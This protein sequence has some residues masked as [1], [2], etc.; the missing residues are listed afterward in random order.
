MKKLILAFCLVVSAHAVL[1]QNERSEESSLAGELIVM[2]HPN[3]SIQEWSASFRKVGITE[4]KRTQRLAQTMNLWRIQFDPDEVNTDVALNFASRMQSTQIAQLNHTNLVVRNTP[5][6]PLFEDQW[7]LYNDGTNGGSGT[8]DID[9]RLAWDVT[10]GGVTAMGDT[11]VV[12]VIDAGFTIDHEDLEANIFINRGEVPGN[13]I[14]DDANGYIDDVSGWNAYSN[15][16]SQS[17]SNHGTHVAGTVGA[18]GNNEIGVTGVNWNVKVLPISGSSSLESTVLA[19]Y[20]YVLDMRR[21]YNSTGGQKGAY[22]VSTNASFGVDYGDPAEYPNW[23][24]MY[25]SMG[26]AGIIS[27]GA[28]AN[29]NI[30]VDVANDVPTACGSNFLLSVTNTTSSDVKNSGAAFGETTID[31]GAPGTNIRSTTSSGYGNLTGTSMATPHVAGAVALM[32]SALCADVLDGYQGNPAGLAIYMR[33]KLLIEGVDP[34]QSLEGLTVTGGRLNLYK[35]VQS[36]VDSCRTIAF[37]AE[38]ASCG[39]CDGSI[40]ATVIG[41]VAPFHYMWSTGDTS[42]TV[43]QLCAG[44]YTLTVVDAVSDTLIRQGFVSDSGGPSVFSVTQHVKCYGGQSG[45]VTLS[46]ASNYAWSNGSQDSIRTGLSAGS[47]YISATNAS[48]CTTIAEVIVNQPDSMKAAFSA[49]IPTPYSSSNGAL[50]LLVSGG[51]PPYIYAWSNGGLDSS[52]T[53]VAVGDYGV[54]VQDANGCTSEFEHALGYPIGIEPVEGDEVQLY[55]NPTDGMLTIKG[56]NDSE[57]RIVVFDLVGRKLAMFVVHENN[58]A[59]DLSFLRSGNYILHIS[60]DGV[61]VAKQ[62]QILR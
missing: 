56:L 5:N 43:D 13:G 8:A 53:N 24:A 15:S 14:D 28:T 25:D 32:Y 41:G 21:L 42:S 36:V 1:A 60:T 11:I 4:V 59:L 45:E 3:V 2:I 50:S 7:A 17:F 55:P 26:I 38:Q 54:T 49:L 23:C 47:Y 27:A 40:K 12:A 31:L 46:G 16:G 62:I 20:G 30:N 19:S 29:L 39:S 22:V 48:N 58:A 44:T 9:A 34:L 61:T 18:V 6:D 52:I 35:A 57:G 33:S 37:E 51:T 10:T